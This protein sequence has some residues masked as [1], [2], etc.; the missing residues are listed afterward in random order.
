MSY[1]SNSRVCEFNRNGNVV[2]SISSGEKTTIE[3]YYDNGRIK[4][5][6][7]FLG[8]KPEGEHKSWYQNGQ[9]MIH[10]FY[11][12]GYLEGKYQLWHENGHLQTLRHYRKG[13]LITVKTYYEGG[14]LIQNQLLVKAKVF[15]D[16]RSN[17]EHVFA[18]LGKRSQKRSH[19]H[20]LPDIDAYLIPDLS[21]MI[22]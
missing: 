21:K 11:Q 4:R 14:T 13:N 15:I 16:L 19:L 1:D 18:R 6:T 5:Q 20:S 12:D 22:F 2:K 3:T 8:W 17:S 10:E 7:S 9:I